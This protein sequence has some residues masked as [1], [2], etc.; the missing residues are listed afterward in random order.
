MNERK[1]S[2]TIWGAEKGDW[3]DWYN[4]IKELMSY[5]GYEETHIGI[6]SE[7]YTSGK[8]MTVKRKEKEVLAKLIEGEVPKSF[9]CY[10]LPKG[11]KVASFDYDFLCE[12][13]ASYISVVLKEA[14][15]NNANEQFVISIMHK[16]VCFEYGE[17]YSTSA[18]EMP[19]IYA[20]T[21]EKGNIKTYKLIKKFKK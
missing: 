20:E 9:S 17:I 13:N 19:L 7:N 15:Y 18:T 2:I 8:I 16:Y 5:L 14:D 4:D 1:I 11:Y 21:K 6:L 12:R 10:S 3:I